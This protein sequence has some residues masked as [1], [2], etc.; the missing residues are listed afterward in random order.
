M[1]GAGLLG[2]ALA[3]ALA[4]AE[5]VVEVPL[6]AAPPAPDGCQETLRSDG[7]KLAPWPLRPSKLQEG[8]TCEAPE[9]VAIRRGGTGL[10]FEP[11]ARVNCAFGLRLAR[12][13]AIVQEEARRILGSPVRA[14]VQLGTYNCRRMAAYPDLVSEHSFA[15]AIDV[16]TFVLRNGRS[17]V[18]ERDWV[19]ADK[20]AATRAAQFLRSLTRRLY[21]EK[22]FS[23][24]L[25]PSYDSH[26]KNHLH[27]D[28]AAYSVDG[29]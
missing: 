27:L 15:N 12:F 23:V 2:V 4:S 6:P 19:R 25:T 29:T 14:I 13:E 7:L 22:V 20:P 24:V 8:V 10:R 28:G 18:V 16:A 5:G 9:G 21:D 3:A 11:S 17:V 26:H 1:V